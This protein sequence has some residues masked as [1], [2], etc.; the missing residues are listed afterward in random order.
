MVR[1]ANTVLSRTK[2]TRRIPSAPVERELAN[3]QPAADVEPSAARGSS[4]PDVFGPSSNG[5]QREGPRAA[6]E[7]PARAEELAGPVTPVPARHHPDHR[8]RRAGRN[9]HFVVRGERPR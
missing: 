4:L 7:L 2:K 9:P 5:Q 6:H 1:G 8:R 3:T